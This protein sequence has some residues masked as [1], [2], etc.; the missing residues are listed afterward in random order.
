MAN[1][2]NLRPNVTLPSLSANITRFKDF[3]TDFTDYAKGTEL[4][5]EKWWVVGYWEHGDKERNG[6][7]DYIDSEQRFNL[8]QLVN[9]VCP[10]LTRVDYSYAIS[11]SADSENSVGLSWSSKYPTA[12]EDKP[13]VWVKTTFNLSNGDSVV[14][15][16]ITEMY[17]A[18]DGSV[19]PDPDGGGEDGDD[20]TITLTI[21]KVWD[22]EDTTEHNPVTVYI[23]ANGV[24]SKKSVE[25]TAGTSTEITGL[26][27]NDDNGNEITYTITEEDVEGYDSEIVTNGYTFTITNTPAGSTEE[28][29]T[30]TINCLPEAGGTATGEGEYSEGRSATVKAFPNS[31]YKF[32]KWIIGE[33]EVR[34]NPHIFA[35]TKNVTVTAV[36][37][38]TSEGGESGEEISV[39]YTS[40]VNPVSGNITWADASTDIETASN[41]N[42]TNGLNIATEDLGGTAYYIYN[43]TIAQ[44]R[45]AIRISKGYKLESNLYSY[46]SLSGEFIKDKQVTFSSRVED[47]DSNYYRYPISKTS[48]SNKYTMA[49][50]IIKE[51]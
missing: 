10:A 44:S 33:G 12:T 17:H 2:F 35:V 4:E 6:K 24:Q 19:T 27:K 34:A 40:N 42:I 36:F 29:Y 9:N 22:E 41:G 8:A 45:S 50:T 32:S 31:G 1:N 3:R 30:V 21:N 39:Q 20:E 48:S 15:Y 46:D 25:V 18:S 51:S 13:Y 28:K 14:S 47:E 16:H 7:A 37:E 38:K 43:T 26:P 11:D 49:F 5:W 23:Y